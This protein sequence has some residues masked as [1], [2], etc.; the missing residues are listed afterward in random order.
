MIARRTVHAQDLIGRQ[1]AAMNGRSIGRIEEM[2]VDPGRGVFEVL[3]VLIGTGGLLERLSMTRPLGQ[4]SNVIV[5]RWDQI[6][7]SDSL[8]PR[9]TCAVDELA[10]RSPPPRRR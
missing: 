6:D 1:V 10:V 5:A 2:R 9:L 8:R 3:E 7:L 4:R